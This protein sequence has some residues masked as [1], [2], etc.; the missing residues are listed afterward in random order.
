[1]Q[2]VKV[3]E[4]ARWSFPENSN[5]SYDVGKNLL[6][7]THPCP[8]WVSCRNSL[9]GQRF[10]IRVGKKTNTERSIHTICGRFC[11]ESDI[12]GDFR[13]LFF[14]FGVYFTRH[15]GVRKL[16]NIPLQRK[17]GATSIAKII[18]YMQC[19]PQDRHH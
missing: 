17:N 10:R 15:G 1:M 2:R 18:V 11:T 8:L 4:I 7:Y 6:L 9:G 16:E 5:P 12:Q 3:L 19:R 14:W 13:R